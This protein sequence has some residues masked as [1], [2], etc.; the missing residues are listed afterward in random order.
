MVE[1]S[2]A[3]T[4]QQTQIIDKEL[5]EIVLLPNQYPEIIFRSTGVTGKQAGPNKYELKI[6]GDLTLLGVTRKITI[7]TEVTVSGNELKAIGEFSIDRSDFKVKAT[8][9]VHGL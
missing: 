8:S 1:T 2:S 6:A 5:R 7:P 9:A 4:D 3:F